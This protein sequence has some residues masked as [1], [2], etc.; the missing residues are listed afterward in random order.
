MY[1]KIDLDAIESNK[2]EAPD[3]KPLNKSRSLGA[4]V[5][6]EYRMNYLST[7]ESEEKASYSEFAK[8]ADREG[9]RKVAGVFKKILEDEKE[10]E[11]EL[12]QENETMINLKTS[13]QRERDK[14]KVMDDIVDQALREKDTKT[15]IRVKEMIVEEHGHVKMLQAAVSELES[16]IC[17][18][19]FRGADRDDFDAEIVQ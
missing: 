3:Y 4:P 15:A 13:I 14:I 2:D 5:N 19:S 9:L 16:G 17:V 12:R 10:H 11:K 18:T 7:L 8:I 6:V 1:E